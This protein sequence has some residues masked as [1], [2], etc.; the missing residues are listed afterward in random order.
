MTREVKRLTPIV[1]NIRTYSSSVFLAIRLLLSDVCDTFFHSLYRNRMLFLLGQV[2][3][4]TF[5][6]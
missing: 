2:S 1:K 4:D 5:Y 3:Q 6:T